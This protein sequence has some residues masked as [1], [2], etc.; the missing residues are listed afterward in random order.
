MEGTLVCIHN[1]QSHFDPLINIGRQDIS[2]FV[3]FSH[4]SNLAVKNDFL[5][6]GYLSQSSSLL[7]LGILEIYENKEYES[8]QKVMEL[9]KLKNI[10]LPNTM[11]EIF[12][13]LVLKFKFVF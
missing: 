6:D 5:V 7:N 3:N 2:S 13:I 11:G 12:K 8:D 4:L 10:L 9:N 1:H